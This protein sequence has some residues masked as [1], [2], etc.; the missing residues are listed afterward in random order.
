MLNIPTYKRMQRAYDDMEAPSY[1]ED[2]EE[3]A[4]DMKEEMEAET[5]NGQET[6]SNGSFATHSN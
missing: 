1:W 3:E 2:D 6:E 5:D 4:E